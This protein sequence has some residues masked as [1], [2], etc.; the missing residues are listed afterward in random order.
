ML[1]AHADLNAGPSYAP[2]K[3]IRVL[4]ASR[5]AKLRAGSALSMSD[6]RLLANEAELT[7]A[8]SALRVPRQANWGDRRS[9]LSQVDVE[10][11]EFSALSLTEAVRKLDSAAAFVGLHGSAF[12]NVPFLPR[13]AVVLE[14]LPVESP[15]RL[16]SRRRRHGGG[17]R[18]VAGRWQGGSGA[19]AGGSV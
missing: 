17:S 12:W 11:V 14:V 7:A 4:V 3:P 9:E 13:G 10:V 5:A 6:K 2:L 8:L 16:Q 19:V 1:R 18:A 15:L